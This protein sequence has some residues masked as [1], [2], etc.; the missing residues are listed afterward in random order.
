M[1][2][3]RDQRLRHALSPRRAV[4]L[5][6]LSTLI[7]LGLI[8]GGRPNV[9]G[10]A[11]RLSSTSTVPHVMLI[12]EENRPYNTI[13]GSPYAP[14]INSLATTY[15]SATNWY[16]VQHKSENDYVELISGSNQGIPIGKPYA[17]LTLVDELHTKGIPWKAYMES[18]AS[19][20]VKGAST[21]GLY[22]VFHNAF[23]YF[24]RYGTT[25]GKWCST[26]D[27]STE[28]V[29]PYPGSSA[30]VSTLDATGAP[31]FVYLIPNDCHEMHGDTLTGSTCASDNQRQLITAGDT[32][33]S[34]NLGPVI[35]SSWFKQN[36]I[37]IITWDE[38]GSTDT[39]GCCG[40]VATGGHIPT[41]VITSLN[42]GLGAFPSAGDHYG[43]LAGIEKAF[44]V[45][46]L[47]NS[48]N[49]ING[50][51]GGAFG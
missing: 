27:L 15:R 33:L 29:V 20:C 3:A 12:V 48:A 31:D 50:N 36:G 21:N 14:Y 5:M 9:V 2:R 10:I 32:W 1:T 13:I 41:I 46:L 35:N 17:A 4:G 7:A 38:S 42:K 28:G 49:T 44:G 22:D 34:S 18:M 8:G 25:T 19:D 23:H 16:A 40:G 43:T 11:E 26:A 39:S 45:S 24:T 51:L 6:G 30:L 37:I 47:L